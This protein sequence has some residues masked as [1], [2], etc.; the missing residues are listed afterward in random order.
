MDEFEI[1]ASILED[2]DRSIVFADTEHVIRYMNA[3]AR[4]KYA[5]Y[6]D[7]IG[8]N[9]FD[10]HNEHSCRLITGNLETMKNG[11]D[12]I[13]LVATE[14]RRTFMRSVRNAE[15]DLLGYYEID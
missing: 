15:G 9:L 5:K 12:E 14:T 4:Q 10:C 13:P 1:I 3:R 11:V 6:G 7:I 8:K 2:F